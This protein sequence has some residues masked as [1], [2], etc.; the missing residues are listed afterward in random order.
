MLT[1]FVRSRRN[2]IS[3]RALQDK[4]DYFYPAVLCESI[5]TLKNFRQ[6]AFV[7]RYLAKFR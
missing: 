5:G 6:K 3:N 4:A 7:K 1:L 2:I